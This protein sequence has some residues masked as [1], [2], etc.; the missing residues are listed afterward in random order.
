MKASTNLMIGIDLG[1]EFAQICYFNR[2]TQSVE[3]VSAIEGK[4]YLEF[5]VKLVY[6]REQQDF[7]IGPEADFYAEHRDGVTVENL[8]ELIQNTKKIKVLEMVFSPAQLLAEYLRRLLEFLHVDEISEQIRYLGIAVPEI[9]RLLLYNLRAALALIGLD[10]KKVL[11]MEYG[12]SFYYYMFTQRTEM[13]NRYIGWFDFHG[14]DVV[15]RRL[16][17]NIYEKPVTI[18]LDP[19]VSKKLPEDEKDRD[20]EFYVF[21]EEVLRSDQY[22]SIQI[23]GHGFDEAWA[24]KSIQALCKN[25]RKV[26]CGNNLFAFGVCE[27]GRDKLERKTLKNF[28]FLSDT[29]VTTNVGMEMVV[30]GAPMYYPLVEAGRNWFDCHIEW[31]MI[32]DR[33]HELVFQISAM[34]EKNRKKV[35][36]ELADLPER[37]PKTTRLHVTLVYR[38]VKEC[39]IT[40]YDKGFGEMFPSSKLVWAESIEWQ[41]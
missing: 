31:D 15:F 23:T 21:V 1:K 17:S 25:H 36:M 19:P 35:V 9:S 12:E 28:Q 18:Q 4:K 20:L 33:A 11:F 40:V 30:N 10:E 37:P 3:A 41:V 39:H 27:A 38:S 5:P 6:R 22:S 26:F 14:T 34:G 24:S 7:C 13:R 8:Y 2:R 16:S 32:L 29:I